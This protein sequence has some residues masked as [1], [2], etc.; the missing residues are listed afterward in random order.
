M[1]Y[2]QEDTLSLTYASPALMSVRHDFYV[3]EGGAHGNYGT[4]NFNID[5]AS[6][7]AARHRRRAG[8][9]PAPPS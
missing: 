7:Q 4:G 9:E 5:M 8:R 1:V 2:A 6:G 3:N